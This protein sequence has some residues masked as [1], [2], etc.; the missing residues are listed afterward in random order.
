MAD[1]LSTILFAAIMVLTRYSQDPVLDLYAVNSST[2][3]P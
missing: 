1:I 3:R 2:S